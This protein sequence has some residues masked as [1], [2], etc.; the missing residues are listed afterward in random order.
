MPAPSATPARVIVF[1]ATGSI[2]R[3]AVDELLARGHGVTA[4]ARHPETLARQDP[5]LHLHAGD[6][7]DPEA[8]ARAMEGQ[9]AVV[10][11]L[12]AGRSLRSR[13]RSEG[14]LVI[15]RAMQ[16]RGIRRLVCQSTLGAHESWSNLNF[17]WKRIMFGGLL[18]AVF[19]DHERQEDMVRA[20]GLDW[21]IVRPSAFIEGPADA[22]YLEDVPP[23]RRG[24]ALTIPRAVIARFLG[25]QPGEARY[26][27]R[28]VGISQ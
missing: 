16:A 4:F 22:A 11:T 20:S 18:R 17:Y 28:A 7:L 12:G 6:V 25:R 24:L 3:L 23:R 2:G 27:G 21:T 13:V 9:Q 14:T 1:G 15:I 10:I 8:V 5:K 26:L 19:R